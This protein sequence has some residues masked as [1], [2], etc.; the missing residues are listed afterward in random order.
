LHTIVLPI[1]QEIKQKGDDAVRHYT[2]K[3]DKVIIENFKV[4]TFELENAS[5]IIPENLK[6]AIKIAKQNIEKFHISQKEI[7]QKIET[8][9]GITCWRKSVPIQR[10]GLYV[11][12]QSAPMFSTILMLGIPATLAGC[13]EIVLCTP[14]QIDGNIHP[15]LLYTA[16]LLGIKN[17]FKCGG[18]QAIGAMS[19]GTLSIPKVDKIFGPSNQYVTTAKQIV[20]EEGTAIDMPAGPSEV[21]VIADEYANADF[22]ASDLLSQAE[23]GTSSQVVLCTNSEDFANKVLNALELQTAIQPR[24]EIIVEALAHSHILVFENLEN[25]M[26]FSNEYAPEHLI[27][28][29]ENPELLGEQVQNA[30]SV[31]LGAYSPESVGDYASGTNHTLPTE[32]FARAYSGVS[33]DSFVKKITFQKLTQQG[34]KNIGNAVEIMAE[35]E[36]FFAHKNAVSVRLKS[37]E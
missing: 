6:N 5:H 17:V 11:P 26:N 34:I 33:L 21:L 35:A 37:L 3:F 29:V 15:A 2:Q 18:V 1:L 4:T 28:H 23:H 7:S 31:F 19:Y 10:V 9:Q 20:A 13:S 14:P 25:A 16:H 36:G 22:V 12:S 30:G 32:G 27:L 24:K 8:M